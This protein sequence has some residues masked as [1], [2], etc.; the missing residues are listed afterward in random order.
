[1]SILTSLPWIKSVK[2]AGDYLTVDAPKNRGGQINEALA[3]QRVYASELISHSSSLED[4]FLQL[5][6]GEKVE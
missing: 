2:R 1:M 5:T 6:G 3:A 4:I